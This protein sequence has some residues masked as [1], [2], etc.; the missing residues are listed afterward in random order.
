MG[1]RRNPYGIKYYNSGA[2][3]SYS[4]FSWFIKNNKTAKNKKTW[5]ASQRTITS[6]K[7]VRLNFEQ[8][9]TIVSGIDQQWQCDL[10]DIQNLHADND[11]YKYLLVNIDVFS[12]FAI[13]YPLKNKSGQTVKNAFINSIKLRKPK[14]VQTDRGSE[15]F[16]RVLQTWF[17]RNNIK[18]FASH[19]YDVK[20]A[21]VERF[22]RT[23]KSRMWR[24][25][26]QHNTKRYVEPL[27]KL[28]KS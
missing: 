19:N 21:V 18:H 14:T 1:S 9:K 2:P 10:C 17:T 13:V 28:V 20:A 22:L 4:G 24:Y 6:H 16:N 25:F 7:P 15:Y 11:G 5:A 8:R 27:P 3:G 12:K 23:L 26:K